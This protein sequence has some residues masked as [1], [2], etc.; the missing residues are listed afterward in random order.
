[1]AHTV[2]SAEGF[3]IGFSDREVTAWGGLVLPKRMLDGLGFRQAGATRGYDP[4]R[5]GR[6]SH[7]PLLAFGAEMRMVANFWLRPGNVHGASNV[8]QFLEATPHHLEDIGVGLLRMDRGFFDEAF[9]AALEARRSA[10]IVAARLP[11]PLHGRSTAPPIGGPWRPA[12][13]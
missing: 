8:L 6:P 7:H 11:Q 10:C 2:L 9:L 13:N 4:G 3:S 12:W 5:R 1:M